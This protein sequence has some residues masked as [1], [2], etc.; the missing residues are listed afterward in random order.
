M[1]LAEKHCQKLS[2]QPIVSAILCLCQ[3]M[4]DDNMMSD[5]DSIGVTTGFF[6]LHVSPAAAQNAPAAV[7]QVA[8]AAAHNTPDPI[9][10]QASQP[11][12]LGVTSHGT[13]LELLQ[14][15]VL[16]KSQELERLKD[17]VESWSKRQEATDKKLAMILKNQQVD[18]QLAAESA[19]ESANQQKRA[20]SAL[21]ASISKKSKSANRNMAKKVLHSKSQNRSGNNDKQSRKKKKVLPA[22]TES[23]KENSAPQSCTPNVRVPCKRQ[24][25]AKQGICSPFFSSPLFSRLTNPQQRKG[26]KHLP[27]SVKKML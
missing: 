4:L 26:R 3:P 21:V 19:A 9:F 16:H 27:H 24:P 11:N 1:H 10:H 2:R 14:R 17:L 5:D 8:Q 7:F 25:F 23:H 15:Q 20:A 13:A 22:P 12:P 18:A 6:D